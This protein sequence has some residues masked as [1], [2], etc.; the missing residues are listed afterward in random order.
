M[1]K[2]FT[3]EE[4]LLI[5]NGFVF[6]RSWHET[7]NMLSKEK[8]FQLFNDICEY[9]LDGIEPEQDDILTPI[10]TNIKPNIDAND[11]KA[12]DGRKGGRPKNDNLLMEGSKE[13]EK[14]KEILRKTNKAL[15]SI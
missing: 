15:K 11:K 8:G 9:A 12:K 14:A 5:R 2:F 6:Y 7:I 10:F 3:N 1:D 13:A 4:G